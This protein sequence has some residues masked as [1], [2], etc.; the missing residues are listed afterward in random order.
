MPAPAYAAKSTA[1]TSNASP[2]ST[3]YMGSI[4]AGDFLLLVVFT[5]QEFGGTPGSIS[6]P[7]GWS[8]VSGGVGYRDSSLNNVGSFSAFYKIAD[9]TEVGSVAVTITGSTGGSNLFY[10]QMYRFTGTPGPVLESGASNI[11]GDGNATITVPATSVGGNA[12]TLIALIGQNTNAPGTTTG[13]TNRAT[14]SSGGIVAHLH[15]DTRDDVGSDGLVTA[16]SGHADGWA[17]IHLSI[18]SPL[19]RSFIVN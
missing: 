8:L 19:G 9:G 4:S 6:T 11:L 18:F 1:S 16:A 7:A 10:S 3:N 15:I 14:D 17:T 13:Y 5:N 2:H 12:R